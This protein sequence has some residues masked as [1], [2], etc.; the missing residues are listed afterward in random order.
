MQ[1]S[2]TW[3]ESKRLSRLY[4]YDFVLRDRTPEV[5]FRKSFDLFSIRKGKFDLNQLFL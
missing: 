1:N 4:M 3:F 5:F 2:K